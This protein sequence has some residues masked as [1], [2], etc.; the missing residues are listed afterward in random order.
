MTMVRGGASARSGWLR[1]LRLVP[2]SL[3]GRLRGLLGDE[4]GAALIEFAMTVPILM[5]CFF[6]MVQVCLACYMHQ[7][8]TETAREGSRYA[9]VRGSTCVNG[10]G[11][12][13]TATAASVNSYVSSIGWPNVAGGTLV[14]NTTYPD[15]NEQPGSR[16]QVNVSYAFP[17]RIPF[18][19]SSTLNLTSQSVMYIVQ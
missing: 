5:T 1:L 18:V 2:R 11:S 10:S 8:L 16:V 3:R 17:F 19:P 4:E 6:G 15:G 9:I 14:V 7:V 13:C 12:S